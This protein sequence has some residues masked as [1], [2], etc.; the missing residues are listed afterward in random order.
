MATTKAVRYRYFKLGAAA[1][2]FF[3]PKSGLKIVTGQLVRI[4]ATLLR[5]AKRLKDAL[6]GGHIVEATEGEYNASDKVY[7]RS[8][9]VRTVPTNK[10]AKT[11]KPT[12]VKDADIDDD[13][14]V[15]EDDEEEEET[16][17]E[18]EDDE[19][20]DEED[21]EDEDDAT[22]TDKKPN[23]TGGRGRGRGNSASK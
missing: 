10:L 2:S 15:V 22:S 21:D 5:G 23:T 1:R 14:E 6:Q 7:Q 16:A 13:A 11:V 4:D 3:D 19:D 9:D 12:D 20:E 17:T 18:D 8:I